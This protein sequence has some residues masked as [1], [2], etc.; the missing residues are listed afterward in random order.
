MP[1]SAASRSRP[2][3]L[4]LRRGGLGHGIHAFFLSL[5]AVVFLGGEPSSLCSSSTI[6]PHSAVF[7]AAV[8]I[9][10]S[11]AAA[12]EYATSQGQQEEKGKENALWYEDVS[13]TSSVG[14][15]LAL[16]RKLT[17]SVQGTD[18]DDSDDDD[19]DDD[20]DGGGDD[21]DD[22]S[23][24]DEDAPIMN[25]STSELNMFVEGCTLPAN[26]IAVRAKSNKPTNGNVADFAIDGD[27]STW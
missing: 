25:P 9:D 27:P 6:S 19:D 14:K 18:Y 3:Q 11:T 12:G 1:P 2:G 10:T 4:G 16:E 8:A 21:D 17:P 24:I 5:A 23:A 13:D 7:A 15:R 22:G 20:D 26:A